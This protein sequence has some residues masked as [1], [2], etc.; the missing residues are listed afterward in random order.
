MV[1]EVARLFGERAAAAM[2]QHHFSAGK[3]SRSFLCRVYGVSVCTFVLNKIVSVTGKVGPEHYRRRNGHG[4][5]ELMV[6]VVRRDA[7]D[8]QD[9]TAATVLFF[10]LVADV[11]VVVMLV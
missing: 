10:L 5:W 3:P 8:F 1:H 4:A 11:E 7:R 2:H 6:V 9:G